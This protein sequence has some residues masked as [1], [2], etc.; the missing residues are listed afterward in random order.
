MLQRACSY[1]RRGATTVE[2]A[3]V[4][5]L[6]FLLILGLI[7][8]GVGIFRYQSVAHLAREGARY[9]SV[10]GGQYQA[11]TGQTSPTEQAIRDY[12]ISHSATLDTSPSALTV[13]VVVNATGVD[14]NNNPTVTTQPWDTSNKAP[15]SVV[16]QNGQARQNTVSVTVTYQW[17]PEVYLVGPI[18]L[19]STATIPMQY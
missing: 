7:V 17:L 8:G 2:C 13:Q 14:G 5:P 1:R 6:T 3:V 9:A 10:R 18:T 11:E 12:I 19:T 16:S 4:Y 15:Y